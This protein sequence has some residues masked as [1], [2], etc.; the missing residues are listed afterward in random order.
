MI[1]ALHLVGS[2]LSQILKDE[3]KIEEKGRRR[4]ERMGWE[5]KGDR[6][7]EKYEGGRQSW[8]LERKSSFHKA[9]I[10]AV[11]KY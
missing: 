7:E 11:R 1:G 4:I 2:T 9:P 5:E 3:M 8:A 6:K 10:K